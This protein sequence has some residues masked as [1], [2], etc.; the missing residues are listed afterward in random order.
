MMATQP[1]AASKQRPSWQRAPPAGLE[2][3]PLFPR[4][5][6]NLLRVP[7]VDSLP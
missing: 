5:T 4:A 6:A 1:R 7:S 3:S 2:P